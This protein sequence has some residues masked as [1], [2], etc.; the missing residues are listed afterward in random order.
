VDV[1][2]KEEVYALLRDFVQQG[3]TVLIA[4]SELSEALMCDRVLVMAR[5]RITAELD[6]SDIDPEGRSIIEHYA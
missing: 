2:A 4:S 1:E 3:G 6:R 5:G